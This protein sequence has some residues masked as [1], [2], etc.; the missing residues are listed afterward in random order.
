MK[1]QKQTMSMLTAVVIL[2]LVPIAAWISAWHWQNQ[3]IDR[4]DSWILLTNS[5][6]IPYGI[7]SILVFCGLL[8]YYVRP[9]TPK[10]ALLCLGILASGVL[11]GQVAKVVVKN[12]VE[13]PRPYVQWLDN[14]KV[15]STGVFY[16]MDRGER[17][18]WLIEH[19]NGLSIVPEAL[20]KH[21]QNEVGYAFP[22][23]HSLFAATW[24]L[25][26]V[27]LLW[28]RRQYF[29]AAIVM[30]WAMG[31]LISRLF[32]GMH[33]PIDLLVAVVISGIIAM[34]CVWLIERQLSKKI[35]K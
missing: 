27:G 31:V 18:D 24:A 26:V 13:E 20:Q 35:N 34:P 23:G 19:E 6:A 17:K 15:I 16:G 21:W 11:A 9:K 1:L 14:N 22:S 7:F 25:L 3:V 4:L 12:A 28:P 5:A 10:T 32:L 29:Q 2:M 33:W 8:Y 30:T